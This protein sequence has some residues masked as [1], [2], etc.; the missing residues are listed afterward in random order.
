MNNFNYYPFF[1]NRNGANQ[2]SNQYDYQNNL[3]QMNYQQQMIG[4]PPHQ[5]SRADRVN[6]REGA[7]A[8]FLM[9]NSEAILLDTNNPYVWIKQTDSAGYGTVT[10]FRIIPL[11]DDKCNKQCDY[12]ALEKRVAY[13]E[14]LLEGLTYEQKPTTN[15]QQPDTG[16]IKQKYGSK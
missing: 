15:V 13:L 5:G 11:E 6:G 2:N 7:E 14:E 4:Q 12:D 9:P 16:N 10:G 1:N 3:Q 8:Y